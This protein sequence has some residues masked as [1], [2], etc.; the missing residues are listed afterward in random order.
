ME[1]M[2]LGAQAIGYKIYLKPIKYTLALNKSNKIVVCF[3]NNS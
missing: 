3:I 2:E 1:E